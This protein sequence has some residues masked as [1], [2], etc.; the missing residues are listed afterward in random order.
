MGY[1]I[2]QDIEEY[3][4]TTREI[5]DGLLVY[6]PEFHKTGKV[7]DVV[8]DTL[9]DLGYFGIPIPEEYG[10]TN[11][12]I[13]ASVVIQA[14][15]ARLPPQFWGILRVLLGPGCK[16]IV[17]HGSKAQKDKWLPLIAQGKCTIAFALSEAQAGSDVSGIRTKAIRREDEYIIDGTKMFIS[18]AQRCELLMVFAYT[19]RTK[20]LNGISAFLVEPDNPGFKVASITEAMGSS[21]GG[22]PEVVFENCRVPA[23]ALL[24]EEGMG[25]RYAMESLNDGRLGCA[26]NGVG[27]GE[28]ALQ[29]S[30]AYAKQR[31]AFGQTL[32]DFQSIQHMLAD[33][34][35]DMHAARHILLDAA[36]Q[37]SRGQGS[38][39]LCSMVKLFASEA[40]FRTA[41]RAVQIHGGAGYCRGMIVERVF[42]DSRGLRIYEGASEIQRNLIGK[43]L[44]RTA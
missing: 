27:M 17:N 1:G 18:N 42:R 5:V 23:S 24:G 10:G 37:I 28:I 41:D 29:E 9:R 15:L 31:E 14:E 30:V 40:A 13:F 43:A 19:D 21:Y 35:V 11:L 32:G 22:L 4:K 20:G 25:F 26:A 7:P 2:P 44:L 36:W 12:G 3:R 39:H 8:T 34:A 33:M 16:A 6:E 38:A